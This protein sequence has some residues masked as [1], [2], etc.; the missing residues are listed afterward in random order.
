MFSLSSFCSLA[1][2]TLLDPLPPHTPTPLF[3]L[4]SPSTH[5]AQGQPTGADLR[6]VFT[7]LALIGLEE[8]RCSSYRTGWIY[9]TE[10]TDVILGRRFQI[11]LVWT[12]RV[13]IVFIFGFKQLPFF[14]KS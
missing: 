9:V 13:H 4:I 14:N 1:L 2:I 7:V 6:S 5:L 10:N 3:L 12:E 8:M 11:S